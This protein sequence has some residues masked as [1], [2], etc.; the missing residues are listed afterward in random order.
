M[1]KYPGLRKKHANNGKQYH[2]KSLRK[3]MHNGI[4]REG[5]AHVSKI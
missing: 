1:H 5:A 2:A 4:S 3:P